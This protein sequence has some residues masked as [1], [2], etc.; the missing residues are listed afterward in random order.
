MSD[1]LIEY[2]IQ[3]DTDSNLLAQHTANPRQTASN[4][5]VA[6]EDVEL[7]VNGTQESLQKRCGDFNHRGKLLTFHTPL[8]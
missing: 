1:R 4:F 3:L 2:M 5:G 7:I 8:E 6:P